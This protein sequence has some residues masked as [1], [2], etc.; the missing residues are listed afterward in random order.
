M[1]YVLNLEL[2]SE[3]LHAGEQKNG[4]GEA[5]CP[6]TDKGRTSERKALKS[7]HSDRMGVHR[8]LRVIINLL[9]NMPC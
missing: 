2:I 6:Y 1:G 5:A 4:T 9:N 3:S 8:A 7:K